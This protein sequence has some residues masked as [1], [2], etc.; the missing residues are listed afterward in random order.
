MP[1]EGLF[2]L[3]LSAP[4]AAMDAGGAAVFTGALTASLF[5]FCAVLQPANRLALI[6]PI[7]I[8]DLL[9][10]FFRDLYLQYT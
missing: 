2:V 1:G 8:R 7:R 3:E 10:I 4:A 9:T 6:N 5:A